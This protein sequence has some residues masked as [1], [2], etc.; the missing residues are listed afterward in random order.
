MDN[1]KRQ[2]ENKYKEAELQKQTI[3]KKI[4]GTFDE[5]E[6]RRLVEQYE[7]L[8]KTIEQQQERELED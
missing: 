4:E 8:Q 6:K 3:L 2:G 1:L 7:K 5:N